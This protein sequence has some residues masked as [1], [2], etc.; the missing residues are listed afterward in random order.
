MNQCTSCGQTFSNDQVESSLETIDD[1]PE[2]VNY[3]PYCG[4]FA[5]L[6]EDDDLLEDVYE[7]NRQRMGEFLDD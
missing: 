7:F 3:C 4:A 2:I 1:V 6:E 5:C